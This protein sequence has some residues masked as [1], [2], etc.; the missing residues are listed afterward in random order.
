MELVLT[1]LIICCVVGEFTNDWVVRLKRGADPDSV[2][3]E[4]GL[5]N[6]GQVSVEF[7]TYQHIVNTLL[8]I[9]YCV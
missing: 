1:F 7:S 9:Q 2:A 6:M 8:S 3:Q 4:H 5:L